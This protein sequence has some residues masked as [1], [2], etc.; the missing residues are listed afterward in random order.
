[1]QNKSLARKLRSVGQD[2]GLRADEIC[3]GNGSRAREGLHHIGGDGDIR[4]AAIEDETQRDFSVYLSGHQDTAVRL[5]DL[6]RIDSSGLR[7]YGRHRLSG[8][9]CRRWR[10]RGGSGG[11]RGIPLG[12]SN[13][14]NFVRRVV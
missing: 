9:P 7:L 13:R 8:G 1:M 11:W 4:G 3:T 5:F 14:R 12:Q 10:R 2:V 6:D